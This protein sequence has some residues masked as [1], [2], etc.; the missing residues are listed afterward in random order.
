MIER[1]FNVLDLCSGIGGFSYAFGSLGCRT[2]CYVERDEYAVRVLRARM[3]TGELCDAP[4]WDDL[5]TFD[6]RPWRGLVDCITAGLPCQPFSVAGKQRGTED[7]R[8]LWPAAWRIIRQVRPRWVLL[9]N[10]PGLRSVDRGA[11]FGRILG[12]LASGG[13]RVCWD[14]LPASAF[15]APHRRDRVWIVGHDNRCGQPRSR[16][17]IRSGRPQQA[18][19]DA[20]GVR[21]DVADADGQARHAERAASE[22]IQGPEA[23]QRLGRCRGVCAAQTDVAD[24]GCGLLE[25]GGEGRAAAGATERPGD[26]GV[27]DW[28]A[29]EPAVGRVAHGIP[30]RVDRLRCLGNSIVPQV[31]MW[32]AAR[33]SKANEGAG[34]D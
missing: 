13:F 14:G 23:E 3:L 27:S 17:H 10:V 33:I 29:V 5:H 26:G 21:A 15:G 28:W 20:G 30:N 31:A 2:V 4:I 6:G 19:P 12:D 24:A 7:E 11:V 34:N 8:H 22:E 16:L 32:I 1:N 18:A 9:E 25:A